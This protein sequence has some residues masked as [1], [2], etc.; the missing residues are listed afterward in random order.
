MGKT[1]NAAVDA[2][3]KARE[4]LLKL[5]ADR[6]ARDG[7]IEEAAAGVIDAADRLAET[8]RAAD[9]ERET[10]R[11]AYDA[12]LA[13]IDKS[14]AAAQRKTDPVIAAGLAVLAVEK[15]SPADMAALT[16]LSVTDVRRL[17]G[18]RGTGTEPAD[19]SDQGEPAIG[20]GEPPIGQPAGSG[21]QPSVLAT[22]S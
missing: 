6:A 20:M 22:A 21:E 19:D 1:A 7:R 2:R 13:R 17:R 12:E 18:T 15:V 4:R 3:N 11:K 9:S 10:A 5:N 16:G 8:A 14:Q